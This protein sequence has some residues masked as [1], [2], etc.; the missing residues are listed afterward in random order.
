MAMLPFTPLQSSKLSQ[1]QGGK[2]ADLVIIGGGLGGVA[3]AL[4]ALRNG[5]LVVAPAPV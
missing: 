2:K 1:I 5:L 3:A 4:A